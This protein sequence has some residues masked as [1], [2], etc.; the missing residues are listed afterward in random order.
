MGAG[1]SAKVSLVLVAELRFI[2]AFPYCSFWLCLDGF[3]A[4]ISDS[5]SLYFFD[6]GVRLIA[7]VLVLPPFGARCVDAS[8]GLSAD[9][10]LPL[11]E[12]L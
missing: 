2:L 5:F 4:A 1:L 12:W 7:G 6:K 11:V 10:L 9:V 3:G 8:V